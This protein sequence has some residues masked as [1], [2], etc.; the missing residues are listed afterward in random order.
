VKVRHLTIVALVASLQAAHADDEV[1]QAAG[2]EA[3]KQEAAA[4]D[5]RDDQQQGTLLTGANGQGFQSLSQ[6]FFTQLNSDE[7][8]ATISGKFDISSLFGA[9]PTRGYLTVTAE[10]PLSQQADFSNLATLDGLV[11]ASSVQVRLSLL[12]GG[13]KRIVHQRNEG[14][15]PDVPPIWVVTLD[16]KVGSQDHDYYDPTTL[17][18]HTATTTPWQVGGSVAGVFAK[19]HASFNLSFDYQEFFQDGDTGEEHSQCLTVDNCVTGFIGAPVLKHQGLLSG[20]MRWIGKV[21][22]YPLGVELNVTYDPIQDAEAVQVPIYFN[23]DNSG[24]LTGGLRFN[25][26]STDHVVTVGVFAS[27]AFNLLQ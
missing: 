14:L 15:Q 17:I 7:Q 22:N 8:T 13:P 20:D 27:T 3:V 19:G 18:K 9:K 2:A 5:I 24:S 1:A 26:N 4:E 23:T 6:M 10:T 11:K 25:W 16:G 21:G 12:G